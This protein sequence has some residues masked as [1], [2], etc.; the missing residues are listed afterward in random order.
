MRT[1]A[2]RE[3][4]RRGTHGGDA[5]GEEGEAGLAHGLARFLYLS[6]LVVGAAIMIVEILGAKIL[7]PFV[8]TSHFV[9][10]AQ[11]GVTLAALA[12]GYYLGGKLSDRPGALSLLYAAILGAA[13]WLVLA[14]VLARPVAYAFIRLPLAIGSLISSTLLYFPPL[15]FLALASPTLLRA[16]TRS[17]HDVGK[18]AGRMSA[19]GTAGSFLGTA[20]VAYALIPF[21][22]SSWIMTGTACALALLALAYFLAWGRKG[23]GAPGIG[24]AL[25]ALLI[26]L[27]FVA[28]TALAEAAGRRGDSRLALLESRQSPYGLLQV[29]GLRGSSYL[30][31]INDYLTQNTYDAATGKSLSAFTYLL[32]G[33]ASAYAPRLESALCIGMGVGIV[34]RELAKRGVRVDAVE[35]NGRIVPLAR[36][37]FGL[38]ATAFDLFIE[39]GRR[40]LETADE[41]YDAVIVDAFVGDSSPSHLMSA[42]AFA[43][44]KRVLRP[45]GVVVVNSFADLGDSED[46]YANSLYRTMNAV[47]PSVVVHGAPAGNAFFVASAVPRLVMARRPVLSGIHPEVRAEVEAAYAS[48]WTPSPRAGVVLTDDFNPL[49]FR[50]AP[51]REALRR[52]FAVSFRDL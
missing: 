2:A 43:A 26:P 21:V 39:D 28:V 29:A 3:R 9:W 37:H 24:G 47:F 25:L 17:A 45:D 12:A 46:F 32:E 7:A 5:E 4:N 10:T 27:S 44:V 38:D 52:L 11:I 49:E 22:P 14:T 8:G 18:N 20:A 23:R 35:I 31:F 1:R 41:R 15:A 51:K 34:P 19:L 42:E 13:C 16:V 36:D 30:F 33:L 50:D 6:A 48:G 40:F